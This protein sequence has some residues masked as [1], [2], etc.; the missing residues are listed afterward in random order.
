METSKSLETL[1]LDIFKAA[2]AVLGHQS[3]KIEKYLKGESEKLAAT[4]R[5]IDEGLLKGVTSPSEA[6]VLFEMQKHASLAVL[7]AAEGMGKLAAEQAINAGLS[8]IRDFVNGKVGF[9]LL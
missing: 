2:K 1:A 4:I 6:K 8:V 5:I 7:A 3:K 9:N